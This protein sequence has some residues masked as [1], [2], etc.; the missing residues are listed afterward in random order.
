MVTLGALTTVLL[1]SLTPFAQQAVRT[2]VIRWT[3]TGN[4]TMS[5]TVEFP[6]FGGAAGQDEIC[7][8]TNTP[9]L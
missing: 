6:S 1:I 3:P 4:A 2:D 5:R 7:A 8:Y 9:K